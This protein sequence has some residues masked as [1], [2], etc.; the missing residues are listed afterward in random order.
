[1][2]ATVG[3][4][5]S[6]ESQFNTIGRIAIDTDGKLYATDIMNKRVQVID[7]KELPEKD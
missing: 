6:N 2:W 5:G 4:Y 3:G 7:L 1:L